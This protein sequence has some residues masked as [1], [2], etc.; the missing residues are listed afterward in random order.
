LRFFAFVDQVAEITG[1]MHQPGRPGTVSA[2]EILR[3]APISLTGF[4]HYGQVWE[5]FH[6]R[7]REVLTQRT[8]VIVLGDAR[9]NW[10]PEGADIFRSIAGLCRRVIWLNP[11]PKEKWSGNDCII[12]AYAPYCSQVREC[13]NVAQL[14]QII[15]EIL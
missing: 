1:L 11:L 13:R 7:Y 10:Q 15:R 8:T 14:A 9:N 6:N 12:D 3:A 5:C 2:R 4:S